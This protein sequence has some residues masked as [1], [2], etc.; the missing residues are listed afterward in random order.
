MDPGEIKNGW[1]AMVT[2]IPW[3]LTFLTALAGAYFA[4]QIK[5]TVLGQAKGFAAGSRVGLLVRG[6]H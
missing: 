2:I 5:V 4:F 6:S 3:I 1:Q